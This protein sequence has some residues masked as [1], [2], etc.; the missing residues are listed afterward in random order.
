MS[1]VESWINQAVWMPRIGCSYRQE[2]L[3]VHYDTPFLQYSEGPVAAL[4]LDVPNEVVLESL[5]MIRY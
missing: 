2:I 4:H 3:R 5:R 1:S